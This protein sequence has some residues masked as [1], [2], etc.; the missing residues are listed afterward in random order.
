MHERL[1]A[2]K[3]EALSRIDT[4]GA[5][6]L[7]DLRTAYLGRKSE[8]KAL[9]KSLGSLPAEERPRFG[10]AVNT[11]VKLVEE[12][13]EARLAALSSTGDP[14]A[15]AELP[16]GV[17]AGCDYTRPGFA[18]RPG[19]THPLV[20]TQ[21]RI[22]EI[23][24]RFGYGVAEGP[25]VEDDAHNFTDLNFP[26][27]HPARDAQDTFFLR[28]A[29]GSAAVT[30]ET[31][32][33]RT[34]T[35]PVQVRIMARLA[36]P[37]AVIV[38]GRTYRSDPPDATHSPIFHQVEGLVVGPDVT[39]G[40]LK[41]TLQAFARELFGPAFQVRFR[42]SFFPFTEPSAEV[43]VSCMACAA[44]GAVQPG[45]RVCKGTGWLEI[46]G[47]G[48]VDPNVFEAVCRRRGDRAYDPERVTGFAFGMG[49]ERVAMLCH[50]VDDM[51]NF[52]ENDPR[53]LEMLS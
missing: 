42:P 4:A 14:V 51:R 9:L 45:C 11:A 18:R 28:G 12:R 36:P 52:F 44:K 43:D 39:M 10:A 30:R 32:L 53:F 35:S 37:F 16:P 26:E 19:V 31:L 6:E 2:L 13:I 3:A 21:S 27:D 48:M 20:E 38:P 47:A 40:D 17:V 1:E 41:G 34:H 24:L 7:G 29:D 49:V 5:D 8:L 50:G 46:L 25:D 23:F 33:M 15:A 22:E